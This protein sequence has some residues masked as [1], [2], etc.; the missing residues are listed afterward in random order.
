VPLAVL[1]HSCAQLFSSGGSF[2]FSYPQFFYLAGSDQGFSPLSFSRFSWNDEVDI[3]SYIR[4]CMNILVHLRWRFCLG[5]QLESSR[6]AGCTA[7]SAQ[8]EWPHFNPF[9]FSIFSFLRRLVAAYSTGCV[10]IVVDS[11]A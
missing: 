3:N 6:P 7:C 1:L 11:G 9:S 10:A 5:W 4:I 2:S 8:R